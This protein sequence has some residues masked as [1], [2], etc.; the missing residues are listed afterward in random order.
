MPFSRQFAG[1]NNMHSNAEDMAKLMLALLNRGELE[2]ERILPD[3]DF[4]EMWANANEMPFAG[5][6]LG[7][8]YPTDMFPASGV[9]WIVTELD[10][11]V[12]VHSY[13]GER[14][15]QSDMMLCPE[16]GIGVTVMGNGIAGD[17]VYSPVVAVDVL[18]MLMND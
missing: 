17:S 11:H 10:G 6:M 14:G 13:G 7:Q 15:Y 2:G 3:G 1:A 5:F 9:G 8:L 16:L 4:G 18:G 12:I